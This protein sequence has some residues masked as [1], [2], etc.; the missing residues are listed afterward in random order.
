MFGKNEIVGQKYFK[1]AAA[2]QLF[3][4]SVFVTLQGEGPFAGKPAV[5]VRLA[6]CNLACT[7]CDTFFDDGD[8]MSFEQLADLIEQRLDQTFPDRH[9]VEDHFSVHYEDKYH[10]LAKSMVLVIT[11]GEPSLQKNLLGFIEM[12][13]RRFND[14][15]IESNGILM[16]PVTPSTTVVISPKC[17]E[18]NGVPVK[19]FKPAESVLERADCLKFVVEAD[20]NSLYHGIPDWALQWAGW[21]QVY[22][23]PMNVYNDVPAKAKQMRNTGK[24]RIEIDERSTVDEVISFWET[25]LLNMSAN[26]ANH[27]FAAQYALK[28]GLT[29]NLQMHLY[30]SLA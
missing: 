30:A 6:K 24:N 15:Q 18:K 22:V 10:F 2:D 19:Y 13:E 25:G 3:V 4:T 17:I 7:F 11:G 21:G 5:F 27:E 9:E 23:S 12:M 28:H 8:W 20:P 1:E 26:Q 14:I 29:L 16:P